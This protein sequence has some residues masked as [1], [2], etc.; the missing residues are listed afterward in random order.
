MLPVLEKVGRRRDESFAARSFTRPAFPFN[1][2]VHPEFE[3]TL[4]DSGRG[5]RFVGGA[6]DPIVPGEVVLLGPSVPHTW[7]GDA[8]GPTCSA[9]VVQFRRELFGEE[10]LGLPEMRPVVTLLEAAAFGLAVR[11]PALAWGVRRMSGMR[12]ARRV[13]ALLEILIALTESPVRR[14]NE[15]PANRGLRDKQRQRIDR[16]CRFL[17][18]H[19]LEPVALAEVAKVLGVSP[20]AASRLFRRALGCTVTQY[21]HEL[22]VAHACRALTETEE[23]ITQVAFDSGFGNLAHFNRVFRR[24]RGESPRTFRKAVRSG[25]VWQ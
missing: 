4:V 20:P 6:I 1:W 7:R 12:S 16:A 9:T 11:D 15:Q 25:V 23:A 22:R 10:F 18:E 14:L 8:D 21:L 24:L 13:P 19:Y 2:H 3:V 5:Q 17:N